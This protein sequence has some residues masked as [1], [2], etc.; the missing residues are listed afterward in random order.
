MLVTTTNTIEGH[1][2]TRYLGIAA[3][4]AVM[5]VN[6]VKDFTAGL[7][8]IFG[9]RSGAYEKETIKARQEA[10]EEMEKRAADLG[11]NAVV[12]VSIDYESVGGGAML[13]V[14]ASGTA[15]VVA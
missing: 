12:G 10:L 4:E 9:G 11:A 3:G 5:G 6:V 15:V 2:I 7:R 13:M 8:D 14:T 1:Q